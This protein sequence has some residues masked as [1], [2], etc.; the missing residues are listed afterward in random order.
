[1]KI[2]SS[3]PSNSK[4]FANVN[5]CCTHTDKTQYVLQIFDTKDI[6]NILTDDKYNHYTKDGKVL[7]IFSCADI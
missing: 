5:I 6:K 1:M 2:Q 7:L 3:R 4:V